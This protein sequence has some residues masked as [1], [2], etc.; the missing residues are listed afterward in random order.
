M[1]WFEELLK[2]INTAI[3]ASKKWSADRA[4]HVLSRL[5][6]ARKKA[7]DTDDTSDLE[8]ILRE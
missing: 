1:T 3:G 5:R 4:R 2:L 7:E 8:S 6:A